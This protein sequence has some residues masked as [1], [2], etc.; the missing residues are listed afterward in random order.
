MAVVG[1]NSTCVAVIGGGVSGLCAAIKLQELGYQAIVIE[2]GTYPS[3]KVCGEFIAPQS[4][5]F[6]NRLGIQTCPIPQSRF[7]LG[8]NAL[9]FS[10][11]E[12]AGGLS[13]ITLDPQLLQKA[14]ELGA[15][16]LT[17]TKVVHFEP[18][19]TPKDYHN[20]I[21]SNG[22]NLEVPIAI[23]ATGRIPSLGKGSSTKP[24]IA[25]FVGF[26]AHFEGIN[27]KD[28]LEM[29][30]TAGGYLGISPIE[31]KKVNIA[32]LVRME[33]LGSGED[34]IERFVE[35]L[36]EQNPNL[37]KHLQSGSNLFVKWLQTEVPGFGFRKTPQWA[38][39]YFVGDAALAIPPASGQGI[40]LAITGG[41][42]AAQAIRAENHEGFQKQFKKAHF[43][44]MGAAKVLHY[45]LMNPTMSRIAFGGS[46]MLPV[47]PKWIHAAVCS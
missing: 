8:S 1:I 21:L 24:P 38:D 32:C 6:L 33:S 17:D 20:I 11:S 41:L 34:R 39:V 42:L 28:A 10:F 13:H 31:D 36:A 3:H 46:K 15:K 12:V 25:R 45:V 19:S 27:V 9:E 23:I 43:G 35:T 47:L 29:Y 14:I 16:V 5:P 26:K 7:F 2:S 44:Q 4:L 30:L 18:K 37:K 40:S 22:E